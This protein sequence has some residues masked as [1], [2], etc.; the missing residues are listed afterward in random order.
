MVK[1][2]SYLFIIFTLFIGF[3]FSV[4]AETNYTVDFERKGSIDITL[5]ETIKDSYVEGAEI[6]IYHVADIYSNNSN[7][8]HK[9][10]EQFNHCEASLDD[11]TEDDFLEEVS[12]C[13]KE[14]SEGIVD[15]T[16]ENGNVVFD[17]LPLGLYL[18][19]Q[20][21]KVDGYSIIDTFMAHIPVTIDN[22]WTYDIV[23]EPKTEIIRLM[24]V[25]VEKLWDV[26]EGVVLP[27]SIIIELLKGE[28][29]IDEVTLTEE[30][31]WTYT[32]VQ[33]DESDEYS[34]REKVVPHGYSVTYRQ[35]GNKFIVTNIR[36]LGGTG[37]EHIIWFLL[38]SLGF[39][40]VIFGV[41]YDRKN[42]YE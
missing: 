9:Y 4:N 42:K 24:D 14:D 15:Y 1:K 22:S 6:T 20:T 19:K 25:I 38:G 37:Q 3:N 30:D 33:I 21:N 8:A 27:E 39:I 13:I 16:D 40:L 36:A 23:A 29:V 10:T 7:L 34:V 18:V 32:W 5:H 41:I 2:I 17:E 35:E 12:K 28:E 31:K 11:V 26:E